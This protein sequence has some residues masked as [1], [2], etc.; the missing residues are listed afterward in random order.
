MC[1]ADLLAAEGETAVARRVLAFVGGHPSTTEAE[2]GRDPRPPRQA[3]AR[4]RVPEPPWPGLALDELM[5]RI[6][7]EAAVAH[8]PL[9]ALLRR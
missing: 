9:V 3:R 2:R 4:R 5:Q 7:G 8:A 6:V 1:F